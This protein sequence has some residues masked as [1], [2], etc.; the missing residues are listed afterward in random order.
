MY[1]LHIPEV[2][3]DVEQWLMSRL[4]HCADSHE[5]PA[6]SNIEPDFLT[7][8]SGRDRDPLEI[9]LA[10]P[11]SPVSGKSVRLFLGPEHVVAGA[12]IV[13]RKL[14]TVVSNDGLCDIT[15]VADANESRTNLRPSNGESLPSTATPVM[16]LGPLG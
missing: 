9:N 16:H 14:P 10:A 4:I 7:C 11:A 1:I 5:R 12:E 13:E 3:L 6:H 8:T 15:G 2:H